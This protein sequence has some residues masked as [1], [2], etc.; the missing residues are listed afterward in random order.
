LDATNVINRLIKT[1][2]HKGSPGRNPQYG[3]GI[4]DPVKALTA[5]L[6]PVKTNPLGQLDAPDAGSTS[7]KAAAAP[8]KTGTSGGSNL[9]VRIAISAAVLAIIVALIVGLAARSRRRK[10]VTAGGW[11][12]GGQPSRGPDQPSRVAAPNS[13]PAGPGQPPNGAAPSAP[14]PPTQTPPPGQ[15]PGAPS[16][17]WQPPGAPPPTGSTQTTERGSA[18]GQQEPPEQYEIHWRKP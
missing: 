4:V 11:Q 14:A 10:S 5:Q 18:S 2:D 16:S 17:A 7:S 6:D 3:Y 12:P 15:A 13:A 8:T 1:A 9:G